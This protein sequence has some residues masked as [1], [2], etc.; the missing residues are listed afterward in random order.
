LIQEGIKRGEFQKGN[1]EEKVGVILGAVYMA[2]HV[3]KRDRNR[4]KQGK[5]LA[6]TLNVIFKGIEGN[7]KGG[8]RRGI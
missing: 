3:Q 2:S 5:R 6:R 4:G 7:Q 1:V 8:K